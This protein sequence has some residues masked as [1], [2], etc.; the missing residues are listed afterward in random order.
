MP[1]PSISIWTS[2]LRKPGLLPPLCLPYQIPPG[3]REE[4]QTKRNWPESLLFIGQATPLYQQFPG[5]LGKRKTEKDKKKLT[6]EL[7]L[8][9]DPEHLEVLEDGEH[10]VAHGAGPRGDREQPDQVPAQPTGRLGAP[11]HQDAL[12]AEDVHANL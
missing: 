4:K 2:E 7:V 3:E 1:F 12:A 11:R 6:L 8:G 10:D 5:L 9:L